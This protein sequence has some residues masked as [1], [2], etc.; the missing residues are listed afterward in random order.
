MGG[1][2]YIST[3]TLM[4]GLHIDGPMDEKDGWTNY[5]KKYMMLRQGVEKKKKKK[6]KKLKRVRS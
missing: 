1:N 4:K 3:D 5:N 2:N 6:N